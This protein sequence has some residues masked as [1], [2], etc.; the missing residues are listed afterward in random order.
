MYVCKH[1]LSCKFIVLWWGMFQKRAESNICVDLY[2]CGICLWSLSVGTLPGVAAHT[3][4]SYECCRS[5]RGY[6]HFNNAWIIQS[7]SIPIDLPGA[8]KRSQ[9][10]EKWWHSTLKTTML[11]RQKTFSLYLSEWK[12]YPLNFCHHSNFDRTLDGQF[13]PITKYFLLINP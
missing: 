9:G 2:V 8:A 13:T 5:P 4:K 6:R 7:K 12:Y 10:K 1:A 3:V 11:R